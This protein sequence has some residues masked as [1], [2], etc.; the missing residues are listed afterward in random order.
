MSDE[1]SGHVI[2]RICAARNVH[3]HVERKSLPYHIREFRSAMRTMRVEA[4]M[5]VPFVRAS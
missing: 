4:M 5:K 1:K 3:V 2:I